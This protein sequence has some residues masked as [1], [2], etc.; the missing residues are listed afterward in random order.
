MLSMFGP[1]RGVLSD[2]IRRAD[3]RFPQFTYQG[4]LL[5]ANEVQF[6][7]LSGLTRCRNRMNII[8]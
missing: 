6:H 1:K 8:A 3:G 7:S 4:L 5:L 2:R